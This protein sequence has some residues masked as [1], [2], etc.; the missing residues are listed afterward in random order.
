M[1]ALV[2]GVA[3]GL[4]LAGGVVLA[5]WPRLSRPRLHELLEEP[6]TP[7]TPAARAPE[8]QPGWVHRLGTLG[9]PALAAAGLPH[10]RHPS[11]PGRL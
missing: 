9:A 4:L 6:P 3:G 5:W 10:T 7:P 8:H 11:A 2:L 1:N